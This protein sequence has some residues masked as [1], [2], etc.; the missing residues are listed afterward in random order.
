[1]F[2]RFC[3]SEKRSLLLNAESALASCSGIPPEWLWPDDSSFS[4]EMTLHL[5]RRILCWLVFHISVVAI[6]VVKWK[7]SGYHTFAL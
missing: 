3:E 4:S 7:S 5:V 2:A 1:M 6:V